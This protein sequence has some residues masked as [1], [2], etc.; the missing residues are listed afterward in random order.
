LA[1]TQNAK[2]LSAINLTE[3]QSCAMMDK[4]Q[5]TPFGL[6]PEY[7]QSDP[8]QYNNLQFLQNLWN[9]EGLSVLRYVF[10]VK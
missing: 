7:K 4:A 1:N 9:I 2:Y 8:S 5:V 3:L 10:S 6:R